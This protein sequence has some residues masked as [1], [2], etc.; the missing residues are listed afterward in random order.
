MYFFKV[1]QWALPIFVGL[2]SFGFLQAQELEAC[3]YLKRQIIGNICVAIKGNKNTIKIDL[4]NRLTRENVD[5]ISSVRFH[6]DESITEVDLSDNPRLTVLPEFIL[7][8]PNLV[9]LDISNTGIS[10]W[11]NEI[12]QLKK[13][14]KL[15]G[16]KN[17]YADNEIPFH[18][19]CLESLRVLN[20]SNSNIQYIDEYIYYL[21]NLEELYMA[22]NYL[23]VAPFS[24]HLMPQLMSVDFTKNLF[25][26][27]DMNT[28][29]NCLDQEDPEDKEDCIEDLRS[30]YE[31]AW[32]SKY[33][34]ERGEP[35]R[36]YASMTET[37]YT[38]FLEGDVGRN[39]CYNHW[40]KTMGGFGE[41]GGFD[42]VGNHN[43]GSQ[44]LNTHLLET[45]INGKTIREWRL[46]DRLKKAGFKS[47]LDPDTLLYPYIVLYRAFTDNF[48]CNV[49]KHLNSED[50]YL[51][52]EHEYFPEKK[53][54]GPDP[55]REEPKE[56]K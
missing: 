27:S 36:R 7:D 47:D 25:E 44:G 32:I 13:L 2:W 55:D 20:M 52:S 5:S 17:L 30:L 22:N 46:F 14:E 16:A 24:L 6:P 15:I 11:G 21:Q 43:I 51:A 38:T 53:V 50:Y 23:V 3:S 33:P 29:Y 9:E 40:L 37:E 4:K 49:K 19:F 48:I 12:C 26:N 39:V 41:V 10:D 54:F 35:Y 31:C 1:I 45:T 28:L 42:E 34:Y 56:C 18:T 8:L